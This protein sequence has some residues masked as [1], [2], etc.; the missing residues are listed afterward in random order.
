MGIFPI[1]MN[2]L[3][4]WLID[5]IVK[6]NGSQFNP[7]FAAAR[8]SDAQDREPLFRDGGDDT[9]PHD[10]ENV[11]RSGGSR[12]SSGMNTIVCPEDDLPKLLSAPPSP[13]VFTEAV[14]P[15]YDYPPNIGSPS[16]ASSRSRQRPKWLPPPSFELGSG[17][18]PPPISDFPRYPSP[19]LEEPQTCHAASEDR[20]DQQDQYLIGEK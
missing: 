14:P 19:L 11:S 7:P 5:S 13:I 20:R 18:A 15:T 10:V 1:I 4:F 12:M 9:L 16:S 6:A 17:C 3:Q 8:N 2:T